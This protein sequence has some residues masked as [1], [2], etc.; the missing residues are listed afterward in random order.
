M[1]NLKKKEVPMENMNVINSNIDV[2]AEKNLITKSDLISA[3]IKS[4]HEPFENMETAA[5]V[6]NRLHKLV[7]GNG[8]EVMG[9]SLSLMNVISYNYRKDGLQ[10]AFEE[11]RRQLKKGFLDFNPV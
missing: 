2:I 7:G 11:K 4:E 3:I 8:P 5:E 9:A 6:Y 1:F 10:T